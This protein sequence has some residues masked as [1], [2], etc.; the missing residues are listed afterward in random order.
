VIA[1]AY[2]P[3]ETVVEFTVW[4]PNDPAA[5]GVITFERPTRRFVATRLYDT[6]PGPIRAFR[7]YY[8]WLL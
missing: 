3:M 6:Q 5:P 8:G 4:D 7:M 1:F 2:R